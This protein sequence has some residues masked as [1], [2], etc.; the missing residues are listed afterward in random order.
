M[1]EHEIN[2]FLSMLFL[3]VVFIPAVENTLVDTVRR[4]P[5]WRASKEDPWNPKH[6][7]DELFDQE[8]LNQLHF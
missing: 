1:E 6:I 4:V 3:M 2:P 7:E 8:S 5:H